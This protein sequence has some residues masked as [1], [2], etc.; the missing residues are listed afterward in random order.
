MHRPWS[1]SVKRV[2]VQ[3][4]SYLD[5][6]G[7]YQ[8]GG[9][10]RFIRDLCLTIR[11][12]WKRDAVVV[13]KG[14]RNF[15]TVCPDGVPVIGMK[16][17]TSAKGDLGFA[18]R[19]REVHRP[20]DGVVYASG[21]DAWPF[22]RETGKAVQHGVWWDGP[23]KLSTRIVQRSR[24][25]SMARGTSSILCVDT[26]FINWLRTQGPEGYRLCSKCIYVPNYVDLQRTKPTVRQ[27]GELFSIVTARRFE[28]KRGTM[29]LLDAL[30][31]LQ[32]R[33]LAFRAHVCTV[34]G[35]AELGSRVEA[36]GLGDRVG[37]SEESMDSV[38]AVYSGYHVAV[39]P[40][41]WSEGTSLACVEAICA[42][43]PV[44]ATAVGGLGN[45]VIPGFNGAIAL[46]TAESI[47]DELYNLA[48]NGQWS[49]MSRNCLS[50]RKSLDIE[51]WRTRVVS[52]LES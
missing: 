31:L 9:R 24:A 47:A 25:L 15:E 11:D 43:L 34:G 6:D 3:S 27:P 30:A 29:L 17:D 4:A 8:P 42:G 18:W 38:L 19:A 7:N 46:P 13:Q 5:F 39:V 41:L 51:T 44:V 16:S 28:E 37:I 52:W 36:L 2:V 26:N 20:D 1:E 35:V 14:T 21:E 23:Q 33:G 48:S 40:T 45:L 32:Q 12:V 10:Q 49:E 22:F 50:L